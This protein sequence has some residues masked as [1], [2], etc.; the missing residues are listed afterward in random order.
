LIGSFLWYN[1]ALKSSIRF[2]FMSLYC[3]RTV[4]DDS[5]DCSKMFRNPCISWTFCFVVKVFF[6][7]LQYQ[8]GRGVFDPSIVIPYERES[9]ERITDVPGK[10]R[11]CSFPAAVSGKLLFL[12]P[13]NVTEYWWN[14]QAKWIADGRLSIYFFFLFIVQSAKY[15]MLIR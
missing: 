1:E 10:I 2:F 3:A 11:D 13:F 7:I 9:S 8:I 4:I 5:V 15:M 12:L 6:V 14:C